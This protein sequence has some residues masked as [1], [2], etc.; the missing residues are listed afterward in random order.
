MDEFCQTSGYERKHAIKLLNGKVGR[1][2]VRAGRKA[3]YSDD[4]KVVLKELWSMSDQM[5]SKL[6]KPVMNLYMESYE[7][8]VEAV[9]D[10]VRSKASRV[11]P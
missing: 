11:R 1:R 8:N 9:A 5:C 7:K 4:V 10:E 3:I 6:L 2:Q